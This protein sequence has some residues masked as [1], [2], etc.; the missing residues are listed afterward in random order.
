[1]TLAVMGAVVVAVVA[2][3]ACGVS[4]VTG[5]AVHPTAAVDI[6]IMAMRARL[7]NCCRRCRVGT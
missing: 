2:E 4:R 3:S 7:G 5:S 1:M 6:R